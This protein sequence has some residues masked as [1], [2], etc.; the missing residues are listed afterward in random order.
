MMMTTYFLEGIIL[1][2][3]MS[4]TRYCTSNDCPII[5]KVI[6]RSLGNNFVEISNLCPLQRYLEI[7]NFLS[8][9]EQKTVE[10]L[11]ENLED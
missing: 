11:I 8:D 1:F 6:L 3:E 4:S 5:Q 7:I 9:Y 2:R 10:I